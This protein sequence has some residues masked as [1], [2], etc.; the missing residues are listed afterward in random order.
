MSGILKIVD[1]NA[2]WESNLEAISDLFCGLGDV[3]NI[4]KHA[5]YLKINLI[6]KW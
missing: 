4:L 5:Y 3:I 2:V 1:L 6:L